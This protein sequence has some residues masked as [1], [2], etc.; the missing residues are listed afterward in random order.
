LGHAVRSRGRLAGRRP[1][2]VPGLA[3]VVGALDDLAEPPA[4]LGR[5]YAARVGGRP[6]HVVDLPTGKEG[7]ANLP[8][9]A[10]AVGG[11]DERALACP[12]QNPYSAHSIL[13]REF[14][15]MLA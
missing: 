8:L 13:L 11:Q 10:L 4:V 1:R 3:A 14:P 15:V 12:H 6:L 2:L 5:K 7:A 9:F